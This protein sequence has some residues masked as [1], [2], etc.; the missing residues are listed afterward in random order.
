LEETKGSAT[1]STQPPALKID[2]R[3]KRI[4]PHWSLLA[5]SLVLW[6]FLIDAI[7]DYLNPL[8]MALGILLLLYPSRRIRAIKPL[9][10][11][12]FL[13]A[14]LS[15]WVRL[16]AL[17][18]PF[19]LAFILAYAF[20]PLISWVERRRIPRIVAVLSLVLGL[21]ATVI[22]AAILIIPK[23]VE[24]VS[25]LVSAIPQM[26]EESRNWVS[27]VALPWLISVEVPTEKIW[28]ELQP[29]LPGFTKSIITGFADWGGKAV[30]GLFSVLAGLANVILVPI[31]TIYFLNDFPKI[32]SWIYQRFPEDIKPDALKAY[33]RLNL[34][35]SAFFRGQLVVTMLLGSWI[36]LGLLFWVK[37]PY[38]ILLGTA[39]GILNLIPYVGTTAALIATMGVVAFHPDPLMTGVKTLIVFVTG[40]LLEGNLI[41]PKIVGDKVGL[42]AVAVIFVVLVAAAL[43]GVIGMLVA[44]PVAASAKIL[45][46]V[47]MERV[48]RIE[49]AL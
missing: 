49:K 22:W 41:T 15:M 31:L 13:T 28:A 9:L 35:L 12:A 30:A 20:D 40:Q 10:F 18:T 44:I 19:I 1:E 11:L 47:W 21:G 7:R 36:S 45:W 39:A 14:L 38:A 46:Q 3:N 43:F 29:R 16:S 2:W 5:A 6:V 25:L 27:G 8:T 37:L 42:H 26:Y 33:Q 34:A 48:E 4:A 17:L 24:E 32:R 23:V